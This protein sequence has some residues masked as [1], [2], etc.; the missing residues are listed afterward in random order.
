[1]DW[2]L[3]HATRCVPVVRELQRQGAEVFLA[4][5]GAAGKL[6][7]QEF[8]ALSYHELPGY[9]PRY[10]VKGSMVWSMVS[11]LPHF[12]HTIRMEHKEV[13]VLV[14]NL[15]INAV[16]SDN[17]Y[18]CYCEGLPTA[19][20]THQMH[21]RLSAAWSWLEPLVN[22]RLQSFM[23]RFNHVWVPDQPASGL[24]QRF[25]SNNIPFD[26]VGWLSRFEPQPEVPTQYDVMAILSGPEPQRTVLESV[27]M[28]QLK[29]YSGRGL[30]VTG[31]PGE[32]I[33]SK[34]GSLEIV[35]HLPAS[36]MED[37]VR[38]AEVIIARSG[39]STIMDL[40]VLGKKA[41]LIPTPQQPE[42]MWLASVLQKEGIAFCPDQQ[43]FVLE[44]AIQGA[45]QSRG[46]G[47][48]QKQEGLLEKQI[49][50]YLS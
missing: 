26:Y 6:L 32:N 47:T 18:G 17:R 41:A 12:M 40:I 10:P 43:N 15:G 3:G 49:K 13:E 9:N 20:I 45:R 23:R 38:K 31:K 1:M 19:F 5:S 42:Q 2:G 36:R 7:R 22:H 14:K 29:K 28:K 21:V 48:Y 35:S 44:D 33:L 4:S 24:T 39:Y 37:E 46:L 11:Q 16:I 8:P 30:I 25:L 34:E 27:L 50:K